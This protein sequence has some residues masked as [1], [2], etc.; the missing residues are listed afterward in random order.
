MKRMSQREERA[1]VR[2][3]HGLTVLSGTNPPQKSANPTEY[4]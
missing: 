3:H 4:I 1:K 2:H